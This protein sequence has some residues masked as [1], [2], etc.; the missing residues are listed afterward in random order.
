MRIK[1]NFH[2]SIWLITHHFT[3]NLIANGTFKP[4]FFLYKLSE[5][6][7]MK[8]MLTINDVNIIRILL[9]KL[10]L[11]LLSLFYLKLTQTARAY[12]L[13]H[14]AFSKLKLKRRIIFKTNS[15]FQSFTSVFLFLFIS[16]KNPCFYVLVIFMILTDM[17]CFMQKNFKLI[18]RMSLYWKVF[19]IMNLLFIHFFLHFL[20]LHLFFLFWFSSK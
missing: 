1:T 12:L 2:F 16:Q 19:R 4:I 7:Q 14:F 15:L 6:L 10:L 3:N 18:I 9:W 8:L 13:F 17:I 20:T 11:K 5:A